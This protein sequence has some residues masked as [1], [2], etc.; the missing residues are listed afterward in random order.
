[1]TFRRWSRRRGLLAASV[2]LIGSVG[3]WAA[4]NLQLF[5]LEANE[6]DTL[7]DNVAIQTDAHWADEDI[8]VQM[9]AFKPRNGALIPFTANINAISGAIAPGR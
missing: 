6:T 2:A 4:G 7:A 3:A 1:M 8:P 5:T 9:I